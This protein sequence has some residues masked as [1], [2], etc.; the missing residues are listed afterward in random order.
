MVMATIAATR[1]MTVVE[2]KTGTAA[3][4]AADCRP[5]SRRR[6]GEP[7][8]LH[9]EANLT[10]TTTAQRCSIGSMHRRQQ[11]RP[12]AVTGRRLT[13][14]RIH[15]HAATTPIIPMLLSAH[16]I[17]AIITEVAP[18][19]PVNSRRRHLIIRRRLNLTPLR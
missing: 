17:M 10:T 7:L 15:R 2:P 12:A 13:T 6:R 1:V 5:I 9:S 11:T 18:R 8:R 3:A 4:I 19:W 14:T 16:H